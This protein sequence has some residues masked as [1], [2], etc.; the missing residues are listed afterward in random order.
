MILFLAIVVVLTCVAASARRVW[1]AAN[2]TELDPDEMIAA[3]EARRGPEAI[4]ALVARVRRIAAADWERDLLAAFAAPRS[5]RSALV[6]E[7]LTELDYR[8]GRW[9]RVPR[10]CARCAV[11][12]GFMLA[13]LVLRRGL[14]EALPTDPGELIV[15]GLIG[16]ALG[17]AALGFVGTAFCVGAH[18]E[19]QRIAKARMKSADRLVELLEARYE[20][21]APYPPG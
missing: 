2:A 4:P 10:V 3:L 21:L 11:T 12:F 5:V 1:F 14:G 13:T 18:K 16:D 6:N 9:S 15:K 7:Q 20:Q 19:A 8:M 17:V